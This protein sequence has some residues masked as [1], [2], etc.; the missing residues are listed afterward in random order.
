[1]RALAAVVVFLAFGGPAA[2]CTLAI[3]VPGTLAI[4]GTGTILSS[5]TLPGTPATLTVLLSLFQSAQVVVGAPVRVQ[6]P[7][8]YNPA[9]EIVE[10]AYSAAALGLLPIATQPYTMSQ[11]SFGAS[12]TLQ[13]VLYTVT[14]NNRIA[15][16]NGFDSGTYG[17]RTTITCHP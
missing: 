14:L 15:N 11:T 5:D 17:T 16:P 1:M 9:G 3:G 8:G 7:G 12:G 4:N 6:S 13:S 2:G 10:V